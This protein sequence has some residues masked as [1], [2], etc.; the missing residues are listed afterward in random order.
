MAIDRL[1]ERQC[2]AQLNKS[3]KVLL[4]YGPRQAGK[5]TLVKKISE[6]TGLKTLYLSADIARNESLLSQRDEKILASLTDGYEL[7]LIDEAQRI[8][9]IGLTLKILYENFPQLKVI[10]T[11]SSSFDLANKVSESLTGRKR[12]FHLL[13]FSM[14]EIKLS[15]NKFELNAELNSIIAYGLYPE[16][17][18]SVNQEDKL[19]ALDEICESYLFKDVLQLGNVK[20][21]SKIRDLL[22]LLAFQIGQ[23]VSLHELSN[24]LGINRETTE[25]YIDLLE[26]AF[27]IFRLSAY[28]RN[29]RKEV[30][31]MDKIFFYD[32]GIRNCL[33][34]NTKQL[35]D[36]NDAG[37]LWE[38][39]IIAERRK[40]LLYQQKK[41]DSYFWRVYTG[42][43]I[44]YVEET[45]EGLFGFEIKMAKTKVKAPKAWGDEYN[46]NFQL[47]NRSNYLDWL[48]S[49]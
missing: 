2:V 9:D 22:K 41:V 4:V 13:P 26:K 20:Y 38:N 8:P 15:K 35:S 44:D 47:I 27:I 14:A 46:G 42:A 32:V 5:T 28:N 6:T 12:V 37:Q 19:A 34:N 48:L 17:Y 23:Q 16:V 43:E 39:F 21:T 29:M 30:S 31:K 40:Q 33:I 36:R 7:L 45:G 18:T 1:V 24:T 10:A 11:G 25:R 49:E 3:S